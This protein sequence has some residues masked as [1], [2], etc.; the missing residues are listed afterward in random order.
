[1]SKINSDDTDSSDSIIKGKSSHQFTI[2]FSKITGPVFSPPFA[3]SYD[4][5]WQ[6]KF[7]PCSPG[8]TDY[9]ALF[10]FAI[11]NSDEKRTPSKWPRR[12]NLNAT[13][14]LRDAEDESEYESYEVRTDRFASRWRGQGS[15]RMCKRELVIG[16]EIIFGV[17]FTESELVQSRHDNELPAD[18]FPQDLI[19]AWNGQLGVAETADVEFNVNGHKLYANS[20]LLAKRS[21]YFY[22]LFQGHWAEESHEDHP[23]TLCSTSKGK[24]KAD[25]ESIM[26]QDEDSGTIL[27]R[28]P[29]KC[30]YTI[31]VPDFHHETMLALLRFLYTNQVT[32]DD[33][34]D[35][36]QTTSFDIFSVADKYCVTELRD[37]A[38]MELCGNLSVHNV[39]E[40]L[41][42]GVARWPDL[43]ECLMEYLKENWKKVK[44]TEEWKNLVNNPMRQ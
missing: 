14:F 26:F 25:A 31:Q 17:T 34:S 8:H 21:D 43:K 23:K 11:P 33:Y 3:T 12:S 35:D 27:Q 13:L 4:M 16:E 42:G 15:K 18:S 41:F 22:N 10:L 28:S 6:L 39:A 20:V 32:F 9:C 40:F 29:K 24:Q 1:M 37:R 5:F 44:E 19:E 38:K 30:K 7:T 36:S 2:D